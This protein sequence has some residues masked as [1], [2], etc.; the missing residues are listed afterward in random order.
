MNNKHIKIWL[1]SIGIMLITIAAMLPVM[2]RADITGSVRI[3]VFMSPACSHCKPVHEENIKSIAQK[4]GCNAEIK[5]FDI[6]DIA[7]YQK[8]SNMEKKYG[9]TGN[10]MPVV[11][12]G[13]DVIG[14]EKDAND[15]LE[16][17]IT[18]Y[19]KEGTAWPDEIS[20]QKKDEP[21]PGKEQTPQINGNQ[22]QGDTTISSPT[23]L[24]VEENAID[25]S[26]CGPKCLLSLCKYLGV[27]ATL[28]E[29]TK[30]SK[31]GEDGASIQGL[32]VAAQ[33]KGLNVATAKV[34]VDELIGMKLPAVVRVTGDHFIVVVPES[35][36]ILTVTD[37]PNASRQISKSAFSSIYP[38][39]D[40]FCLLLS[41][42][43]IDLPSENMSTPDMRLDSYIYN[44]G[45]KN[46][47]EKIEFAI[48]VSN[49]GKEDLKILRVRPTCD[50]LV[51]SVSNTTIPPGREVEIKVEFNTD[52]RKGL[53][54]EGIYIESNDPVSPLVHYVVKG[55][56]MPS[57]PTITK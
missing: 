51:T 25:D 50:C 8:L 4:L 9:K 49:S 23:K 41:K 27:E 3:Y 57:T 40:G 7:N 29:L 54:R 14:G 37:P 43:K 10:E 17:I 18:K 21:V 44:A 52:G 6:D 55:H 19:A 24:S 5:Y 48:K 2:S 34:S 56:F 45:Y 46:E 22:S 13:R 42:N 31:C 1:S 26:L 16:P 20:F 35:S 47:G 39:Y 36:D 33:S 28:D 53:E 32:S 12:I 15:R 11:F 30:A 38:G